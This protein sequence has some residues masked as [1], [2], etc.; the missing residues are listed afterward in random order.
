MGLKES[1]LRGS[2][3]NVS[4]G[5]DAIPDN[6]IYLQDD[7]GDNKLQDRDGSGTTTYNGVEG[8]YRPDWN[9]PRS[10]VVAE[11][12]N[13]VMNQGVAYTDINLNLDETVT[14]R[15]DNI[16][17]DETSSDTDSQFSIALWSEST[18]FDRRFMESS[19]TLFFEPSND[20]VRLIYVDSDIN[21]DEL[22]A[23]VSIPAS[24]ISSIEVERSDGGEFSLAI[25]GTEKGSATDD[26]LESPEY[27]AFVSRDDGDYEQSIDEI[28]VS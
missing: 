6:D 20:E 22:I 25:E 16:E 7:W 12:E 8:V 3:R 1:G 15:Y 10:S 9:V 19:Y 28:K 5:I 26:S 11:N 24:P 21:F 27:T 14:W 17:Y 2:L 23:P 4:V 13:L 18:N